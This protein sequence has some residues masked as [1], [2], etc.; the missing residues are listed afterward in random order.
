M[1]VGDVVADGPTPEVVTAS[2]AFAP[3]L[4]RILAPADYLTMDQVVQVLSE[5]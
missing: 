4:A 2:P 5:P 1:A 3:Q